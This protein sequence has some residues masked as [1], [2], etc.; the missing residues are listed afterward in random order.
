MGGTDCPDWL[1]AEIVVLTKLVSG[2]WSV[3]TVLLPTTVVCSFRMIF[4]ERLWSGAACSL[5]SDTPSQQLNVTRNRTSLV[6]ALIVH[7]VTYWGC[8]LLQ[9]AMKMKMLVG[10]VIKDI[11][12]QPLDV[13]TSLDNR[14]VS[15]CG[16]LEPWSWYSKVARS[17]SP[18]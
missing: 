9:T 16:H 15:V 6:Q 7:T 17:S 8:T 12:G 11:C 18:F 1:L 14:W 13:S 2:Q 5:L 3:C 10:G 4:F